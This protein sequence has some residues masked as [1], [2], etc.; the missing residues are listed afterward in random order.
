MGRGRLA[1][2]LIGKEKSRRVTFEKRKSSLLKKVNEFSILCGVIIYG[3]PTINDRPDVPKICP[4]NPDEVARII[5][6]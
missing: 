4:P 5:D 2:K 6:R 1:L 3:T